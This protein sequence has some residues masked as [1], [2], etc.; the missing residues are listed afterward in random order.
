MTLAISF[1]PWGIIVVRLPRGVLTRLTQG[2]VMQASNNQQI[3]IYQNVDTYF[4]IDI[5]WML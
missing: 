1:V 5:E 4:N 2:Y 3:P